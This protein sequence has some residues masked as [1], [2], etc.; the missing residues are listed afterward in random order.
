MGET[1][2]GHVFRAITGKNKKREGEGKKREIIF[3]ELNTC[4][5]QN[6]NRKY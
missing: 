5:F 6:A 1:E 2:T 3:I 4:L